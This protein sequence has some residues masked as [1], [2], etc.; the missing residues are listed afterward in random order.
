MVTLVLFVL[1]SS[2][3]F[4]LN[5]WELGLGFS[6]TQATSKFA[7]QRSKRNI[8]L[9]VFKGFLQQFCDT[10]FWFDGIFVEQCSMFLLF[11]K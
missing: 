4:L 3:T 10:G 2:P 7:A 5:P 8:S 9:L 1:S 11:F 6:C